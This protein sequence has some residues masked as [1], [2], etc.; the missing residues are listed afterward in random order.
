MA[1][2]TVIFLSRFLLLAGALLQGSAS[3]VE[4]ENLTGLEDIFGR[5]APG[6]DCGRAPRILV[7]SS[8]LSFEVGGTTEKATK[9]EYAAAYGAH[10]YQGIQKVIFPFKRPDGEYPIIMTFNHGETPGALSIEG[11][12]EGWP[13]GPKLAPRNQALVDGSPY[14][15][16]K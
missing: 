4:V 3:A 7:E 12:G 10:D 9:V 2:L 8:G 13:G 14:A 1:R 11:H 16:C 6:G 15:R 5:Y